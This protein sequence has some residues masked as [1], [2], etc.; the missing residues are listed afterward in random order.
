MNRLK[1]G[2]FYALDEYRADNRLM[3]EVLEKDEHGV[4]LIYLYKK[5]RSEDCKTMLIDR[6]EKSVRELNSEEVTVTLLSRT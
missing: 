4:Y 2:S 3:F 5:R 6:E 1:I